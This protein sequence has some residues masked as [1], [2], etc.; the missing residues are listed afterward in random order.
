MGR[1]TTSNT[2]K[3]RRTNYNLQTPPPVTSKPN[4][5][6]NAAQGAAQGVAMGIG[7]SI[8]SSIINSI[9]LE[10]DPSKEYNTNTQMNIGGL[11]PIE[12]INCELEMSAFQLCLTKN[13]GQINFCKDYFNILDLC[14]GHKRV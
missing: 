4:I 2:S 7:M 10:S 6:T 12:N 5:L 8:G 14:R 1:K 11:T 3:M 13:Q 9:S